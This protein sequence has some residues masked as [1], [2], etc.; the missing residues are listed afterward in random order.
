MQCLTEFFECKEMIWLKLETAL[1]EEH[2]VSND[3]QS[4]GLG[5]L[6]ENEIHASCLSVRSSH[7]Q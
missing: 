4:G 5:R 1:A 2:L 7:L 6:Y 3:I